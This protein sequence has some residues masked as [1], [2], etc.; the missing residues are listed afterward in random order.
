MGQQC[1]NGEEKIELSFRKRI[2]F[3]KFVIGDVLGITDQIIFFVLLFGLVIDQ[4]LI[5]RLTGLSKKTDII[6]QFIED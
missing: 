3:V 6:I 5:R 4:E 2:F 1:L